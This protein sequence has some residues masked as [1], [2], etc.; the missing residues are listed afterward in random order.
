[1]LTSSGY[2]DGVYPVFATV[3]PD[4]RVREL[5]IVFIGDEADE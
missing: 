1:V 5:R 3:D 4:G 2:G